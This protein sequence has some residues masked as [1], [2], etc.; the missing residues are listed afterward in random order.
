M[1]GDKGILN[2]NYADDTV[3]FLKADT[4]YFSNLKWILVAF[5][6]VS[7]LKVKLIMIKLN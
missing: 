2:L 1:L 3:I 5:E 6:L 4:Q 7:G